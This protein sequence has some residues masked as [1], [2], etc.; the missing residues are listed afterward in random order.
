MNHILLH[1]LK[2][3]YSDKAKKNWKIFQIRFSSQK[4]RTLERKTIIWRNLF[5]FSD[6]TMDGAFVNNNNLSFN[7]AQTVL[8]W[9]PSSLEIK[10]RTVEKTLEPLVLQ[11]SIQIK[12]TG[13]NYFWSSIKVFMHLYFHT[14]KALIN[15]KISR[16]RLILKVSTTQIL[17][18]ESCLQAPSAELRS[19]CPPQP[20]QPGAVEGVRALRMVCAALVF[21]LSRSM[22]NI[23]QGKR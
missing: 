12:Y 18:T 13:S 6:S 14:K 10:T 11:V 19:W 2:S 22:K 8:N 4:I 16:I 23:M 17:A 9:D 15:F 20:S 5:L 21:N 7:Q 1:L 3:L